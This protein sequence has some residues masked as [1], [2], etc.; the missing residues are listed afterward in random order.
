MNKKLNTLLITGGLGGIGINI[1]HYF[2]NN[3]YN[4]IIVDNKSKNFLF[5]KF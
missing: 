2:L 1:V 4:V 5:I 3:N